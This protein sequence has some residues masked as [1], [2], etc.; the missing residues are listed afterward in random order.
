M[1]I[2]IKCMK[3]HTWVQKHQLIGDASPGHE[4]R[5]CDDEIISTTHNHYIL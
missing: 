1:Q 3:W 2:I 5:G 4:Q